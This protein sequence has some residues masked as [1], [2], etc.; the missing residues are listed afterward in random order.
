MHDVRLRLQVCLVLWSLGQQSRYSLCRLE[1]RRLTAVTA[2]SKL[3]IVAA[4]FRGSC[5]V[6]KFGWIAVARSFLPL[7]KISTNSGFLLP[8]PRGFPL[9]HS[10][11]VGLSYPS[12]STLVDLN[13][14]LPSNI[15]LLLFY[16]LPH[17][18]V[19][20]FVNANK[21]TGLSHWTFLL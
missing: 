14:Q 4:N 19:F 8:K 21:I 3:A 13:S 1:G 20:P 15:P 6:L 17:R 12:A 5:C 9:Q 11:I 18:S 16:F 2:G 10:K 7:P